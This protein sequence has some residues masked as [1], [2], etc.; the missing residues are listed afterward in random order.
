[1]TASAAGPGQITDPDWLYASLRDSLTRVS[2]SSVTVGVVSHGRIGCVTIEKRGN[3]DVALPESSVRLGCITKLFTATLLRQ[4]FVDANTLVDGDVLDSRG[5]SDAPAL[6]SG[7]TIRDLMNHS[8][9]L[10]DSLVHRAPMRTDG[11][12]EAAQLC[13]KLRALPV[14]CRPGRLHS[15]GSAGALLGAAILEATHGLRYVDLLDKELL[16][17]LDIVRSVAPQDTAM[18]GDRMAC[19]A[20]G[21]ALAISVRDLLR[22]LEW[23]IQN[24]HGFLAAEGNGALEAELVKHPGWHS[25]ERGMYLGWKH[26]GDGWF[27]HNSDVPDAAVYARVNPRLRVALVIASDSHPPT[28]IA[29]ALFRERW[30]HLVRSPMPVLLKDSRLDEASASSFAGHYGDGQYSVRIEGGA[31]GNLSIQVVNRLGSAQTPQVALLVRAQDEIF[32]L[33][34]PTAHDFQFVQ[35]LAKGTAGFEFLWIGS[36]ILPR[37]RTAA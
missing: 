1:M 17:P 13:E 4:S 14:I 6:Q 27:G 20:T 37:R 2:K 16:A 21:G 26:Y 25:I 36:R 35:F 22:F 8:H 28:A 9:G 12:I 30:P 34:P 11:F 23:Q 32:F 10:D 24:P 18:A 5:L 31:T 33:R 15:Y 29:S 7:I 3:A 19:P